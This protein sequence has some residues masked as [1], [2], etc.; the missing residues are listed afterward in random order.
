LGADEK[1]EKEMTGTK[2][3]KANN[4]L[5]VERFLAKTK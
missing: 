2:D 5:E 3:K 4:K 1:E